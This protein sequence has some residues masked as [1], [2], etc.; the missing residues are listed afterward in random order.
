MSYTPRIIAIDGARAAQARTEAHRR[1][2]NMSGGLSAACP[3]E[4]DREVTLKD[5]ARV[6]IRPILPEDEPRLATLY[7][8][9]SPDTAYQRFFG[10]MKQLPPSWAH[11]FANVDYRRRMALVAERSLEWRPEL[12]G[13]ARYEPSG[14]EDTAEVAL[15][16]QDYWQGKDL[17][18][19]LLQDILR[20]AEANGIRRFCAQVLADNGRML[21]LLAAQTDITRQETQHGVMAIS[22]R[23]RALTATDGVCHGP[24]THAGAR[25]PSSP[26]HMVVNSQVHHLRASTRCVGISEEEGSGASRDKGGPR[27]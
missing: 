11:H 12:I 6:R 16:V 4:F 24:A 13:V 8:R 3:S 22:F 20:A 9:L 19:I 15:V 10:V 23:R 17:G 26:D 27:T 18:T 5:G 14:E 7:G 25:A 21:R 1:E 2:E